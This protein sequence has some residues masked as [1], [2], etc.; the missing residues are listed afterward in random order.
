VALAR[1][2]KFTFSIVKLMA[3]VPAGLAFFGPTSAAV[4][5]QPRFTPALAYAMTALFLVSL[6]FLNSQPTKDFIYVAF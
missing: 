1:V 4:T 3:V 5:K 6:L 2:M